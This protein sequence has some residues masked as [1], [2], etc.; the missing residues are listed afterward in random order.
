ML[1]NLPDITD[2][3]V[4]CGFA[5]GSLYNIGQLEATLYFYVL[6]YI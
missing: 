4:S 3:V 5:S 1:L 6:T 2:C